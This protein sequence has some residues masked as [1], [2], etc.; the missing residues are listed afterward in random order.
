MKALI[1]GI[2]L[3]ITAT[4]YGNSPDD[5]NAISKKYCEQN[6]SEACEHLKCMK[7]PGACLKKNENSEGAKQFKNNMEQASK[8]CSS[9][10]DKC[11]GDNLKKLA[12]QE[13]K[14]SA[15]RIQNDRDNC[16]SGDK[17]ACWSIEMYDYTMKLYNS[18]E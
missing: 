5:I 15:T 7:D 2:I 18:L 4:A 9:G 16:K 6:V 8:G 13:I 1:F 14:D 11:I 17:K 12:D 10:D 3:T